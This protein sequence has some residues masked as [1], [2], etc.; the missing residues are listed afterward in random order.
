MLRAAPIG[1]ALLIR[2]FIKPLTFK[3]EF[4]LSFEHAFGVELLRYKDFQLELKIG[5]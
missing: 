3:E 1:T 4:G 2:I 5:S